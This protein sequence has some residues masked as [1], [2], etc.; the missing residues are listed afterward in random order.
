M[1]RTVSIVTLRENH[2]TKKAFGRPALMCLFA[3]NK[4][5]FISYSFSNLKSL[6]KVCT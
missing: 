3:T 2:R 1:K 4:H 6:T 5:S